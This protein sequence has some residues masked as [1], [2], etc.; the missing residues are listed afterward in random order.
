MAETVY[1]YMKIQ[2]RPYSINDL[3]SNLHNEYG[4][5]AVQKAVDKLVAEG[6]IF[7]KV[8]YLLYNIKYNIKQIDYTK[9]LIFALDIWKTKSLLSNS[10]FIS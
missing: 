5:V 9:K 2:N 4:K 10:R 8:K 6:K 3:V 1:K 7:E